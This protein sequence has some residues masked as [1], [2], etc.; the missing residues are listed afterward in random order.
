MTNRSL[1]L[2]AFA[3]FLSSAVA[4]LAQAPDDADARWQP[5]FDGRSLAGWEAVN[6]VTFEVQESRI[7]LVRGMGW[8]RTGEQYRDFILELECRPLVEKYDSGIYF[9]AGLKGKPWP[10]GGWQVNLRHDMLGGLVKGYSAKVPARTPGVPVGQWVKLRLVA[11]GSTVSLDIDGERA[12]EFGELDSESGYIGIQAEDRAFDFR[13]IRLLE[14]YGRLTQSSLTP[15]QKEIASEMRNLTAAFL[16]QRNL[17]A[18][19]G[20]AGQVA[21]VVN[22]LRKGEV[23]MALPAIKELASN[24]S[25][26]SA[27]KEL[28]KSRAGEYAPGLKELSRSLPAGLPALP[29]LP[30]GDN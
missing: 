2:I 15:Q 23:A 14:L 4:V 24:A 10:E 28:L 8:L 13:N 12:W 21:T 29:P 22:A 1:K 7:R 20:A 11:K 18:L 16:T 19:D 5:L 3:S 26:T 6:D 17:S 27:Q 30:G 9:R 25:L